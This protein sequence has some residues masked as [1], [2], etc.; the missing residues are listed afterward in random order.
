VK[1]KKKMFEIVEGLQQRLMNTSF[2]VEDDDAQTEKERELKGRI[3]AAL[4]NI[5]KKMGISSYATI[6]QLFK[7]DH[8]E[9]AFKD[10]PRFFYENEMP[11]KVVSSKALGECLIQI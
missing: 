5:F 7:K 8:R 4:K 11:F 9:T 6:N 1:K 3:W 10:V 2:D